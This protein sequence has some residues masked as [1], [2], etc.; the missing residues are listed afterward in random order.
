VLGIHRPLA[1]GRD[2]EAVRVAGAEVLPSLLTKGSEAQLLAALQIAENL[3]LKQ[4]DS[5][6]ADVVAGKSFNGKVRAAALKTL[7]AIDS[8]KLSE[9]VAA[10]LREKDST[11]LSEARRLMGKTSPELAVKECSAVLEGAASTLGGLSIPE[12]D[13]ALARWLDELAA[14]RVPAGI[15]LEILEVASVRTSPAVKAKFAAFES[16]RPAADPL[17]RWREC[18]EGGDAK[19]GREV[20]YEKAEAACLRCHKVKGEGGDVGPDLAE[21]GTK[22][23]RIYIL[24]AIVEPNAEIAQGYENVMLTLTDGSIVAGIVSGDSGDA[25]TV[26]QLGDG[27]KV[28]VKKATVKERLPVPS[29]MPPGLGEALGKRDLRNVVEFLATLK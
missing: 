14:D 23:D 9:A 4:I 24:R 15:K 25:L 22:H 2:R 12:A 19:V 13:A 10:A 11:L 28:Q 20:F 7:D 16:N 1:E 26:T 6:L 17:A 5:S 8:P 27:S 18:L 29:A 21:I 3:Q